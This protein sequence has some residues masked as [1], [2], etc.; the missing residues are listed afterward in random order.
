MYTMNLKIYVLLTFWLFSFY[1]FSQ[2]TINQKLIAFD[3]PI[4]PNIHWNVTKTDNQENIYYLGTSIDSISH[5]QKIILTKRSNEG[6]LIWQKQIIATNSTNNYGVDF[7]WISPTEIILIGATEINNNLDYLCTKIN[8]NTGNIIWSK[9]YNSTFNLR[10]IPTD[11]TIFEN[12]IL[13]TG[14]S[15][16][17]NLNN[18]FYTLN[19]D[20]AGT[21]IW[22]NRYNYDN[23]EDLAIDIQINNNNVIITGVSGNQFNDYNYTLVSLAIDDGSLINDERVDNG[24]IGFDMPVD[25]AKDLNDNIFVTGNSK[26]DFLTVKFDSLLNI[27]DSVRF[28][29]QNLD[30]VKGILIDDSANVYVFGNCLSDFGY[31]YT[32]IIKY[33]NFLDSVWERD[34]KLSNSSNFKAQ[35][36]LIKNDK[37]ILGIN[38][39]SYLYHAGCN[40]FGNTLWAKKFDTDFQKSMPI[41]VFSSGANKFAISSKFFNGEENLFGIISVDYE[42][43]ANDSVTNP[44]GSPHWVDDEF[45]V[46]F[47]PNEVKL[48]FIENKNTEFARLDSILKPSAYSTILNNIGELTNFELLTFSKLYPNMEIG[49]TLAETIWGD[50]IK[51]KKLWSS[52]IVRGNNINEKVLSQAFNNQFPFVYYAHRNLI[53]K[54]HWLPND[55]ELTNSPNLIDD[56]TNNYH[57]NIKKA[58]DIEK[59]NSNVNVG[60]IDFD[61]QSNFAEFGLNS[62]QK[63]SKFPI[64][65]KVISNTQTINAKSGHGT[66]VASIVGAISNNNIGIS[67]VAGGDYT[68]NNL[69]VTLYGM[70]VALNLSNS[71]TNLSIINQG[72]DFF[73]DQS[74]NIHIYNASLGIPYE[75]TTMS[76]IEISSFYENIENLFKRGIPLI[77]SRGNENTNNNQFPSTLSDPMVISVGGADVTNGQ[78]Y[79]GSSYGKNVDIIAPWKAMSIGGQGSL[80]N[81]NIYGYLSGTSSSAPQVAGLSALMISY[82][83]NKVPQQL[84]LV[85]EDIEA[86]IEFYATDAND[87]GYDQYAGHGFINAFETLKHIVKPTYS[88]QKFGFSKNLSN[89]VLVNSNHNLKLNVGYGVSIL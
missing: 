4:A 7:E 57:I 12:N 9:L 23:A 43:F 46:R 27:V 83:N 20:S 40:I 87:P 50:T 22:N 55:P 33:N 78:Y 77:A 32:K 38:S 51:T 62:T 65:H 85:N 75:D 66:S 52:F 53:A 88:V 49:D 63:S 30:S 41:T 3:F 60:I 42:V 54:P 36:G 58:W 48:N 80:T 47:N 11:L 21:E 6:D 79:I 18:D 81:Q 82:Y 28:N 71:E 39:D 73:N 31:F 17:N 89:K 8:S 2:T 25:V 72:F 34:I 64:N 86:L 70:D 15:Q 68:S 45:I 84:K 76:A 59:G 19:L 44:N 69:G 24:N 16:N 29:S 35:T 61:I 14:I 13:I 37:I 67:G 56:G 26:G 5:F 10:D 74:L 1:V